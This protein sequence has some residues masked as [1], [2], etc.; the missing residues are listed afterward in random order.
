VRNRILL[1]TYALTA[2]AFDNYFLQAAK[3]RNAI[4]E[5]FQ[6]VFRL[7]NALRHAPKAS[8]PNH[9]VDAILH[10]SAVNTA[11]TLADALSSSEREDSIQEYVQ[12]ILT[13]P[14]SLAGLPAISIPAGVAAD[15]KWPVGVTAVT[16]WGCEPILFKL[17][18]ALES[19]L[20][21]DVASV[22]N[23]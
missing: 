6:R 5:D 21:Q 18:L 4:Q 7:P 17:G 23:T 9:G 16:Q 14:A 20:A 10:P 22:N 12:D 11:P 13:V 1:G 3:V 8:L 19:R 2:D 15:D